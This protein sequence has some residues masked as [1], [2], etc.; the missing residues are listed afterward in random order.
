[1]LA[2]VLSYASYQVFGFG[3]IRGLVDGVLG[4]MSCF[5]SACT[6]AAGGVVGD[7]DYVS[8]SVGV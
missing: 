5:A 8:E 1:L 2:V 3:V 7:F 4:G 6:G